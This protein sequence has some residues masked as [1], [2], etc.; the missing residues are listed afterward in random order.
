MRTIQS[1]IDIFRS[2]FMLNRVSGSEGEASTRY[3]GGA[4]AID[5][6]PG[7]S[8]TTARYVQTKSSMTV[9]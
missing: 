6:T 2:S 4:V 3:F 8:V 7:K 1:D 5:G 9:A